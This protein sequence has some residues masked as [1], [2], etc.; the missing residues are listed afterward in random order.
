MALVYTGNNQVRL[1]IEK[2]NSTHARS[3]RK[4]RQAHMEKMVRNEDA[5][6]QRFRTAKG[7]RTRF[8]SVL[9]P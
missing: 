4:A 8:F 5:F 3:H 7:V 6:T 9:G 1:M 2:S